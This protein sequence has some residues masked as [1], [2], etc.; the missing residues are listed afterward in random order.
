MVLFRSFLVTAGVG[1]DFSKYCGELDKKLT[2]VIDQLLALAPVPPTL[3]RLMEVIR[4]L[5]PRDQWQG[6]VWSKARVAVM[7]AI[8][9]DRPAV[10]SA[11]S[12]AAVEEIEG[13][14]KQIVTALKEK[15]VILLPGGTLERYLP[16]YAGDQYKL[17]DDAKRQ[18]VMAEIDEMA[19][20]M[21]G[22]ELQARYGELYEAVCLLPSAESVD[23][24]QIYS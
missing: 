18:A 17:T 1:N 13:R 23:V 22:A 4:E 20:P 12:Q 5:G 7:T 14:L 24:E 3:V 6:K 8:S 15:R 16:R 11:V 9:R 10:I 21:T 2:G 19:K